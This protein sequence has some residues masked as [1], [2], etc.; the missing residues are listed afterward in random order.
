VSI[1]VGQY[2][3]A[4]L[5]VHFSAVKNDDI[6]VINYILKNE[7]YQADDYPG[8]FVIKKAPCYYEYV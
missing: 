2:C 3:H 6:P 1:S 4:N 5:L 8:K 7:E